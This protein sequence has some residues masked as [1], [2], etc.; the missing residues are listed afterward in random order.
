[1]NRYRTRLAALPLALLLLI[2]VSQTGCGTSRT[3]QGAV[4]GAGA[5]A[6][7]GGVI[8]RATGST[9]RGAIIGA[10]VGGT[11]GAIIG[12]QMEQQAEELD[13]ELENATVETVTNPET[14]ETAGIAI[15]FDNALLFD[16]DS[17]NLRPG[18]RADLA[19]LASSLRTYDNHDAVIVGHA[20]TDGSAQ[21]N[22]GLSER[23]AAAVRDYLVSLGV[24]SYRLQAFGRGETDPLPGIP[25]T[26]PENRRVEIAIYANEEYRQGLQ[27]EY[28]N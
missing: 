27:S 14:G 21:Y 24:E 8:G 17:A 23:R 20:S 12:R 25:G 26:S 16:F 3:A 11:A 22:Q 19:D 5:G 18:V 7:V 28:G 15:R 4:I 13:E 10:A 6:V 9:A 2:S 1:M